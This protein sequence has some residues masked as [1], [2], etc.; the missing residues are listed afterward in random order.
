[1]DPAGPAVSESRF[2][3]EAQRAPATVLDLAGREREGVFFLRTGGAPR[4][5]ESLF[6]LLNDE[7]KRF[8]PFETGGAIEFI[9]FDAIVAVGFRLPAE[10]VLLLDEVGALRSALE[11]EVVSGRTLSGVLAHEAPPTAHR[12]SDVLNF[13]RTRF[14]TLLGDD[15]AWAVRLGA[16]LRVRPV[17]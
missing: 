15:R 10:E 7:E 16:I 11:V 6:D 9:P 13:V 14:L 8:L 2:V 17:G 4:H 12:L 3:L 1:V 5:V